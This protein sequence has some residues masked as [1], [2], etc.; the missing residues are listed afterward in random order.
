[1]PAFPE[2]QWPVTLRRLMGYLAGVSDDAGDEE[3][4]TLHCE[5][6]VDGLQR[7]AKGP[8]L[9]EPETRYHYSSYAWILVSAAVETA[10]DEPFFTFMRRQIFEPLRMN[11]TRADAEPVPK[12]AIYYFPCIAPRLRQMLSY[13]IM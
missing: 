13:M 3:P 4:L 7:F 11:D 10:A 8:L 2:K 12:R 9:F 6:T 5:R 1:V